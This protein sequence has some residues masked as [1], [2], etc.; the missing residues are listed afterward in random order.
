MR[1]RMPSYGTLVLMT[2]T[3][4]TYLGVRGQLVLYIHPRYVVFTAVLSGIGVLLTL[5]DGHYSQDASHQEHGNKLLYVPLLFLLVGAVLL[6][7]RTLSS[8]T[9]SQRTTD[10]GSIVSSAESQPVNTLFAGSSKGL[11]L[12]DWSRVLQANTD[13]DYY[14]NK[15]AQVSGF[16]YDAGLGQDTVWLARFVVTCCAVDAQPIGVP[17]QIVGWSGDYSEDEWVQVTGE[18]R[19]LPTADGDQIVLV[20][21]TIEKIDQPGNPYAS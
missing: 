18:F 20:P 7:A 2:A 17:V 3:Y 21:D 10:S 11:R 19:L 4:V 14:V 15:P 6:P 16:V 9:V 13:P 1:F 8:A 12:N 5:M